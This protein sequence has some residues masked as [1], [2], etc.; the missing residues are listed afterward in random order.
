M[1]LRCYLPDI[2]VCVGLLSEVKIQWKDMI[3][4][5]QS[6]CARGPRQDLVPLHSHFS[7][8]P[9]A[10]KLQPCLFLTWRDLTTNA[11]EEWLF[12]CCCFF[13]TASRKRVISFA[14]SLIV[15]C[16]ITQNSEL[17]NA[18]SGEGAALC[19]WL[20]SDWFMFCWVPGP[21]RSWRHMQLQVLESW[22]VWFCMINCQAWLIGLFFKNFCS[23]KFRIGSTNVFQELD[24]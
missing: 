9:T 11:L 16:V 5:Y 24:Q 14:S 4:L 10:M 17:A 1:L 21:L 18:G 20:C 3:S 12:C 19:L 7:T 15:D 13:N 6:L 8:P 23:Q 2:S 22:E